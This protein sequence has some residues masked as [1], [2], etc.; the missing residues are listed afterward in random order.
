[1]FLSNNNLH[2]FHSFF[3]EA[4]GNAG[5]INQIN[6]IKGNNRIQFVFQLIKCFYSNIV[7]AD[8]AN[9]EIGTV[10]VRAT[11]AGA[12]EEYRAIG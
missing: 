10:F 12:E 2:I 5:K 1:M 8:N 6:F 3:A 9:I 4:I 11:D 7:V